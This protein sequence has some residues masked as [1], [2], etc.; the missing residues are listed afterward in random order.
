MQ[1]CTEARKLLTHYRRC[2]EIR[3]LKRTSY[4]SSSHASQHSCLICSLLARHARNVLES[5]AAASTLASIGFTTT[6]CPL[7]SVSM[8]PPP[9]RPRTC[10]LGSMPHHHQQQQQQQPTLLGSTALAQIIPLPQ[11]SFSLSSSTTTTNF[12]GKHNGQVRTSLYPTQST[13]SYGRPRAT[14]LDEHNSVFSTSKLKGGPQRWTHSSSSSSFHPNEKD[15]TLE[16]G[17]LDSMRRVP[18]LSSIEEV[19]SMHRLE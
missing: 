15:P 3:A 6:S 7:S 4:H 12:L 16:F 1:G 11:H 17:I 2:R 13:S 5:T 14:S 19:E 10:S 18:S 8:P 9:P